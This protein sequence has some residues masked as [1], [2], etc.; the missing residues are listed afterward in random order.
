MAVPPQ[1]GDPV[2]NPFGHRGGHDLLLGGLAVER[3]RRREGEQHR[4]G[5]ESEPPHRFAGSNDSVRLKNGI[6]CFWKRTATAL[7]C[8]PGYT[9]NVFAMPY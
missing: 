8:V 5:G 2:R 7:V 9:S 3:E 6:T 1:M 4:G